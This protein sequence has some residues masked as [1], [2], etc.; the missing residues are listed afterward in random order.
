MQDDL[1]EAVI[2]GTVIGGAVLAIRALMGSTPSPAQMLVLLLVAVVLVVIQFMLSLRRSRR[3]GAPPAD[4]AR[5]GPQ[6]LRRRMDRRSPFMHELTNTWTG[7]DEH[8]PGVAPAP[9]Q[10]EERLVGNEQKER[11]DSR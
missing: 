4:H 1:V 6:R 9:P 10:D 8:I 11:G 7:L 5:S 2:L 3:N